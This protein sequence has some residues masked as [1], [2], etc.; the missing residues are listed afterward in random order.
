MCPNFT[1]SFS[2]DKLSRM[3]IDILR[4]K[5]YC[6]SWL[7]QVRHV[8]IHVQKGKY[9]GINNMIPWSTLTWS[10]II[11]TKGVSLQNALQMRS[12]ISKNVSPCSYLEAIGHFGGKKLTP[13]QV[14]RISLATRKRQAQCL[15][16]DCLLLTSSPDSPLD[17]ED[18]GNIF[19]RM[20]VNFYQ[21][22]S[23]A[24]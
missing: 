4:R 1:N 9:F 23:L 3:Y 7:V 17:L 19:L 21:N 10:A 14:W 12:P 13:F 24:S 6:F 5:I 18:E 15:S 20:A 22:T 8:Y 16:A 11:S 2:N